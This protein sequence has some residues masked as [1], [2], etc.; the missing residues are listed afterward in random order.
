MRARCQRG[1]II[2][3]SVEPGGEVALV[4]IEGQLVDARR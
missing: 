1:E 2:A 4:T 3:V